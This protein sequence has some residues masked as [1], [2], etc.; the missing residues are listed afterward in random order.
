MIVGKTQASH[1]YNR[2]FRL[3]LLLEIAFYISL[4]IHTETL[5][6][7]AFCGYMKFLFENH[8]VFP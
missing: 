4:P 8:L 5:Q 2:F 6:T 3:Y 1:I 7:G